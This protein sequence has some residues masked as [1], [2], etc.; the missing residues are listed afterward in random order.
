VPANV[1]RV[2]LLKRWSDLLQ[3]DPLTTMMIPGANHKVDDEAAQDKVCE[4]VTYF[5]HN[6]EA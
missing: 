6:I 2:A 4:A 5:L 1:D 3:G